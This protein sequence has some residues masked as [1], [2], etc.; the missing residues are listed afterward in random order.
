MEFYKPFWRRYWK[1]PSSCL[2]HNPNPL[3]LLFKIQSQS[4]KKQCIFTHV[5]PK[6]PDPL[7]NNYLY[8][9]YSSQPP[10]DVSVM[11]TLEIWYFPVPLRLDTQ[12]SFKSS[13]FLLTFSFTVHACSPWML[14]LPAD[15]S[16]MDVS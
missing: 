13:S 10:C 14:E 15:T 12:Q 16:V 6:I 1:S 5:L 4:Q 8:L 3:L 2:R 11:K 7:L 9:T